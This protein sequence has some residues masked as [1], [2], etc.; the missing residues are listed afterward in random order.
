MPSATDKIV[1][2]KSGSRNC[3][4]LQICYQRK[5]IS[6]HHRETRNQTSQTIKRAIRTDKTPQV[7]YYLYFNVEVSQVSFLPFLLMLYYLCSSL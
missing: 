4:G 2:N 3:N 1:R 6:F 7:T 5:E